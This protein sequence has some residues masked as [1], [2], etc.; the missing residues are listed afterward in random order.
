MKRLMFP[1][2]PV[3]LVS[4]MV[5]VLLVLLCL[6]SLVSFSEE[7]ELYKS[8]L[9]TESLS[10]AESKPFIN[11]LGMTYD[12]ITGNPYG[13]PKLVVD[14]GYKRYIFKQGEKF[15][16][17][18]LSLK[19][20]Q[21][22][23]YYTKDPTIISNVKDLIKQEAHYK[24]DPQYDIH[25]FNGSNYY[26]LIMERLSQGDVVIVYKNICS[27]YFVTLKEG[28]KEYIDPF[29][30]NLLNE[31][32]EFYQNIKNEKSKCDV[33]L[34]K[35]DKH[36]EACFKTIKPWM[37]FFNLYG[38]H[39]ITGGF[40]GGEIINNLFAQHYNFFEHSLGYDKIN[41]NRKRL[42]PFYK[43]EQNLYYG[44]IIFNNKTIYL[45]E[46]QLRLYGGIDLSDIKGLEKDA[47]LKWKE[48][49]EGELAKPIRM[50]LRP[51]SDFIDSEIGKVAY[52]EA[53]EY[54]SNLFYSEYGTSSFEYKRTETDL[55][56]A[57]IK[58]WKQ[59]SE[60]NDNLNITLKC[61]S[62]NENIIAG[63]IIAK[64]ATQLGPEIHL[65]SCPFSY[66]CKSYINIS[67][68][69]DFEF[70]WALCTSKMAYH[71]MKQLKF[72]GVGNHELA[73]PAKMK[74]LFGFSFILKKEISDHLTIEP[75]TS[76][77][78]KCVT[79]KAD[80]SDHV[81]IWINCIPDL[82]IKFLSTVVTKS[83]TEK[84]KLQNDTTYNLMCPD[85]SFI[86]SGFA[87]DFVPSERGE[88]HICAI[89]SSF[90]EFKVQVDSKKADET[91]VPVIV[92]A[93]SSL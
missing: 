47:Y 82:E 7:R 50:I 72:D 86:I 57:H 90:C 23:C 5:P 38:T 67:K 11:Y 79:T 75:C 91:H 9:Y 88:A 83:F 21:L 55:Y 15:S 2:S 42:N 80:D 63:F 78:R 17:Y 70:G 52:F 61:S 81:S 24:F 39:L 18:Y 34:Y 46:K 43:N 22:L 69:T 1:A 45:K 3:S 56:K 68:K 85:G 87:V 33:L 14:L 29:F 30:L 10:E 26:K 16:N 40:F 77:Q 37:S 13:D 66:E 71:E 12:I 76:N 60:K 74:I 4:P 20:K 25:P 35:T 41:L 48:S 36:H 54:Y 73:C 53:L 44:S 49:I 89:G 64:V 92:I 58:N 8:D 27:K 51:F 6:F 93:C 19:S 32:S 31:V 84:V 59:T 65:H 62:E 28:Y